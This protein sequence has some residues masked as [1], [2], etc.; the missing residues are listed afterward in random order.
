[1]STHGPSRLHGAVLLVIVLLGCLLLAELA[2][3]WTLYPIQR[4]YH[5]DAGAVIADS[6]VGY[7]LAPDKTTIMSDGFF[8]A[9]VATD[10][11][12]LRDVFA[13]SLPDDGLVA[14]GDSQ[15]FGHGVEAAQSWPEQ[16]QTMIGVNVRN[17]GVFGYGVNQYLPTV[18]RLLDRGVRIRHVLLGIT[19]ND[20]SSGDD[21]VDGNIVVDGRVA[22]NPKYSHPPSAWDRLRQLSRRSALMRLVADAGLRLSGL[23]GIAPAETRQ[24]DAAL[25]QAIARTRLRLEA[26]Q[27]FLTARGIRLSLV[28]LANGNFVRPEIWENIAKRRSYGRHVGREALAGWAASRG[29][30]F[31]DV[32]DALEAAWLK[33]GR[34]YDWLIIP[35][36]GHYAAG[37]HR[38]IAAEAAKLLAPAGW[39]LPRR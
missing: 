7:R 20:L 9:G 38:V 18:R 16:L 21:P 22:A 36:D 19:W 2:L 1:M 30:G 23:F 11:L 5:F 33:Q 14:I 6:A 24:W 4:P 37:A 29:I 31:V 35:S 32:T 3:R 27:Y 10:A 12:G 39:Q 8:R 25:P 17:G 26:L 15:T 34:R 13:P 28:Y